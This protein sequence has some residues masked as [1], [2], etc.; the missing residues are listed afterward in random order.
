VLAVIDFSLSSNYAASRAAQVAC[1]HGT[2]LSLLHVLQADGEGPRR[3]APLAAARTQLERLGLRL[4]K[5]FGVDVS[6]RATRGDPLREVAQASRE[7]QLLVIGSQ[8]RNTLAEFLLGTPAERIVRMARVPALVVKR[9]A[10]G[11]GQNLLAPEALSQEAHALVSAAL[12]FSRGA[13]VEEAMLHDLVVVGK[14]QQSLLADL[15]RGGVTRR[16][17]SHGRADTLVLPMPHERAKAQ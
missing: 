8:G 16:L 17:L 10:C 3:D 2:T 9:E 11:P 14:R 6:V 7:A 1:E 12:E 15:L 5:Q 4:Q 13:D